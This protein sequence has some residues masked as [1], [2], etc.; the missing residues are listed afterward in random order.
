[1]KLR[2][3]KLYEDAIIPT[4][5]NSTD[6]GLD[7]YSIEDVR[8]H[9][10]QH[11]MVST[12]I[13]IQL[14]KP[15]QIGVYPVEV[16]VDFRQTIVFEAQIRPRSG[17][18]AKNGITIVNTPGTVDND[19]RGEIKVILRNEGMD[20]FYIKKGDR[21]AQMV[22]CPVVTPE[23]IEVDELDDTKRADSGFGSTGK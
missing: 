22:I 18:A 2:I 16:G 9:Q 5:S 13:A 23:I 6:S 17:L 3:K 20:V 10:G 1:M 11:K 14:P 21:I 12:G 19:Y 7:L 4:R 8:I 15:V